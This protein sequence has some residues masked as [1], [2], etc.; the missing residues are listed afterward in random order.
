MIDLGTTA[1]RRLTFATALGSFILFCNLYLFQPLLPLFAQEWAMSET[2]VNSVL[3]VT[4]MMLAISL[5]PCAVISERVGRRPVMITGLMLL[6]ILGGLMSRAESFEVLVLYRGLL[7]IALACFAATAVAYM[8]EELSPSA[9]RVAVGGYISANSLGGIAGRISGGML[10]DWLSWQHAAIAMAAVTLVSVVLIAAWLPKQQHFSAS[11]GGVGAINRQLVMHLRNGALLPAFIVGGVN[12][13][14]FVNLYSVMGFRLVGAPFYVPVG[15]ASL[16]FLCYLAGTVSSRLSGHWRKHGTASQGML[17]GCAVSAIGML[18][19]VVDLLPAMFI[20]LLLVSG[21]AFFTHSLALGWVGENA[22][23]GKATAN[24]LYLVSYYT[25]GS[26]G[27]YL[28]LS[29]WQWQ[30]WWG[31]IAAG[32]V[33]YLVLALAILVLKRN[34]H[35]S[36]SPHPQ[37]I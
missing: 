34:E 7:G 29:A 35:H 15:F 33:L 6:P 26:L 37:Q 17:M 22:Q 36:S 21:G 9:F 5:V 12:F 3:A 11:K 23:T 2:A 14:L 30:A 27:G 1:Y 18:V 13:A 20:G 25:G 16:I 28:L 31:V 4:T 8:A 32:S 24:A 10:G 19:A